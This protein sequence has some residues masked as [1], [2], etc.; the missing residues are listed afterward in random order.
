MSSFSELRDFHVLVTEAMTQLDSEGVQT[1]RPRIG[2]MV[3]VPAAISQLPK[4]RELIDFVSIGSNDLSQYVLAVDRN[5]PRVAGRY[6][7]L[8][9][10]VIAEIERIVSIAGQ[11][12]L[13]VSLCGE[14][15]SD[16]H[17]VILMVALGMRRLSMSAARLP[18]VKW[19][20]RAMDTR[21]AKRVYDEV[22]GAATERFN[23][24]LQFRL[25]D[26]ET[27]FQKEGFAAA[28]EKLRNVERD[29]GFDSKREIEAYGLA[30][31]VKQCKMRVLEYA[32]VLGRA[33]TLSRS[34]TKPG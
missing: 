30:D 23:D 6:D 31:F 22:L 20:L 28:N 13:P 10:A 25:Y 34:A 15:S 18:L 24:D 11:L 33:A 4:W 14:L 29:L 5:N 32:A 16:P 9:P 1:Q 19:L 3:E 17:A 21:E 12:Q 26:V 7:H 27:T 8:H 2:I